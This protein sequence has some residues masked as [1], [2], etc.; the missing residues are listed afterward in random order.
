MITQRRPMK[1]GIIRA[2]Y[3]SL[4]NC[5]IMPH[6][7]WLATSHSLIVGIPSCTFWTGGCLGFFFGSHVIYFFLVL[8]KCTQPRDELNNE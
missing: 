6:F 8:S 2:F 7:P 4:A 3:S 1:K 5:I